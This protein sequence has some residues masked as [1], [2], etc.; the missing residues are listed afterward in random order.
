MMR[1]MASVDAS[2]APR[3]RS[4]CARAEPIPMV[5]ARR[6]VRPTFVPL[7]TL[8]PV[9]IFSRCPPFLRRSLEGAFNTARMN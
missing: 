4:H 1:K 5:D 7:H 2:D 6:D 3:W 9:L 8:V